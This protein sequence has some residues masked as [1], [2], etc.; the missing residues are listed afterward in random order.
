MVQTKSSAG[1][2]AAV[3]SIAPDAQLPASC[4]S[5]RRE[6]AG[7]VV[8]ETTAPGLKVASNLSTAI[9]AEIEAG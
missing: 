3:S 5:L 7:F 1:D 9:V 8:T 2:A 4:L 6:K